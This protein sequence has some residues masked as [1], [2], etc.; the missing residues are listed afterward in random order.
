VSQLRVYW[1]FFVH[2]FLK[3]R[4]VAPRL[5]DMRIA[6]DSRDFMVWLALSGIPR[7]VTVALV[8][9]VIAIAMLVVVALGE[10]VIL[11]VLLVSLSC[12]HIAQLYSCS[13]AI[14]PEV[15]VH[16]LR[17][18]PVLEAADD[19]LIGDVGDGG[20]CL[21]ETPGVGPQGLVH[22]LLHLGQIVASTRFDHGSLEV[23][24]EGPSP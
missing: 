15:M 17:E 10:A 3:F 8:K 16:V 18:E 4:V 13:R 1:V 22:L 19:V 7:V 12:H 23:V 20:A 24:N 9:V 6:L 5:L 21:E 11:L 14:A 2:D